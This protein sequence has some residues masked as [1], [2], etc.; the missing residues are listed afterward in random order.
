MP[1]YVG[2]Y[3]APPKL[4]RAVRT[5]RRRFTAAKLCFR[6][7]RARRARAFA[8]RAGRGGVQCYLSKMTT[9]KF[10]RLGKTRLG[11][12]KVY[13]LR[14]G[15]FLLKRISEYQCKQSVSSIKQMTPKRYTKLSKYISL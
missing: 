2:R 11:G 4:G 14:R 15:N 13:V 12:L 8:L 1:Q 7:A 6:L 10:T 9:V 3:R 5:F